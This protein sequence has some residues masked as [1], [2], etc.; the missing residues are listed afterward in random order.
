[1]IQQ[2]ANSHKPT[3]LKELWIIIKYLK[4]I[5]MYYI[6]LRTNLVFNGGEKGKSLMIV[7]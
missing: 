4:N 5:E 7:K 3:E 1:M 2:Q 6:F